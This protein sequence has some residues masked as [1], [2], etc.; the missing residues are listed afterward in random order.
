MALN[1]QRIH[2]P[3]DPTLQY[4]AEMKKRWNLVSLVSSLGLMAAVLVS[5]NPFVFAKSGVESVQLDYVALNLST[6]CNRIFFRSSQHFKGTIFA[7]PRVV[8]GNGVEKSRTYNIRQSIEPGYYDLTI[9]LYFPSNDEA[10]K[11]TG[12][13]TT[14][15][16]HDACNS[17]RVI[18]D[19]NQ[20]I[21]D[22]EAQ[23]QR[24]SSIPLTSVEMR[25]PDIKALGQIGRNVETNEESD[26]LDYNGKSLTAH[27]KITEAEKNHFQSRLVTPEGIAT[28][29]RFRFQA[30][31]RE[32]SVTAKINTE[33]L[34]QNFSAAAS[35]K[36]FK[37]LGSGDLSATLKSSVTEQSVQ[38]ISEAGKSEDIGKITNMLIDKILKEVGFSMANIQ[39][40]ESDRAKA[41]SGQI[42]VAA[43]AE[44]L[45][46]KIQSEISF[47]LVSAPESATAQT[48]LKIRTD[49]LNDP[50]SIE[51]TLSSGYNDPSL[52]IDL[53]AG[54]TITLTPAYWYTDEIDYSKESREYLTK[55][56]L[57]ILK[58]ANIFQ[59][60]G[61]E[62]L[63]VEN[64][65]VNGVLMAQ[66]QFDSLSYI[67]SSKKYRWARI[68]KVVNRLRKESGIIKPNLA[69]LEK[70]RIF[71][72]FQGLG[73]SRFVQ[74]AEFLK[75]PDNPLWSAIYDQQNGRLFLTAK[76]DL[77]SLR[78][79]ET[80]NKKDELQYHKGTLILDQV[81]QQTKDMFG[82]LSYG[83][84]HVISEDKKAISLQKS[85]TLY[86]TLPRVMKASE[87]RHLQQGNAAGDFLQTI[88]QP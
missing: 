1:T 5:G 53:K 7:I 57:R 47:N 88:K 80:M 3:A 62:D 38:I 82:N 69:E 73:E 11:S 14:K 8:T 19:L 72:T 51:A 55:S 64:L 67:K 75:N 12:A 36:G 50:N 2:Y 74:L 28:S 10:I 24:I 84:A 21:R 87:I 49:K 35:A 77:G 31:S 15:K 26:V 39:L 37:F 32:G 29:I 59:D 70:L 40:N 46:T 61:N 78:I 13:S 52:G 42:A 18:Y 34:A 20:N 83:Q 4:E 17:D 22:R 43:I 25:I 9:S 81:L 71:L 45:R 54:Q 76:K 60:L 58:L 44:I 27:F 33:N 30:R 41:G 16:D 79:R 48:Q 86:V 63:K 85:V 23:I 66:G 65:D 56:D 6:D 68:R